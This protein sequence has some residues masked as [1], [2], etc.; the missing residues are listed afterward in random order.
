MV[1]QQYT[2][3]I[4]RPAP[5]LYWSLGFHQCW[6]GY[7][8]VSD[9][10]GVV[11]GYVK[12]G[13]PLYRWEK[14]RTP[15]HKALD[16][17]VTSGNFCF[18]QWLLK[19]KSSLAKLWWLMNRASCWSFRM[20]KW[21]HRQLV[22][23]VGEGVTEIQPGDHV[24]LCY[25][26]E[27]R[28]CK[29]CKSEKSNLCSK[30]R[31]ATGAGFM[32]NNRKSR[33]SIYGKPIYHSW[34]TSIFSHYTVVHDV[35]VTKIDPQAP[36]DKVCILGCGVPTGFGVVWNTTKVET[37]AIVAI[38]GLVVAEDAKSAGASRIIGVDIDSKKFDVVKN[39]GVTEFV[40][41]KDYDK[42]IQQVLVDLT[43]GGVDYNF[44]CI[45][46]VSIT[47]PFGNC[48]NSDFCINV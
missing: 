1:V 45:G 19:G 31:I 44:E 7:K 9:V 22:R 37:W 2:R 27:C 10:E 39:F 26:A 17:T 11:T 16:W 12:A 5:M 14:S 36:L 23:S 6:W 41:P 13:Q 35:S 29:F 21:L 48:N 18:H 3:L 4:G 15:L 47:G 40:N 43:D 42:P 20:S 8:S 46:N 28:E 34:G 24:I 32:M 33:F 30:V 25:Q 38:F